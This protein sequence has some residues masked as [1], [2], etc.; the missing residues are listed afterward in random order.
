MRNI[1][2]FDILIKISSQYSY[3]FY[4]QEHTFNYIFKWRNMHAVIAKAYKIQLILFQ[5]VK[6]IIKKKYLDLLFY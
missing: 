3:N 6:N 5:Y 4:F 2:G 1:F